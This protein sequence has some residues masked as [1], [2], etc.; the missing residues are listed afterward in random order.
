M[1]NK[2]YI[3]LISTNYILCIYTILGWHTLRSHHD[4]SPARLGGMRAI[5]HFSIVRSFVGVC[6]IGSSGEAASNRVRLK[7]AMWKWHLSQILH[8]KCSWRW[9]SVGGNFW[10]ITLHRQCRILPLSFFYLL[11]S[12]CLSVKVK[13]FLRKM[14]AYRCNPCSPLT[15]YTYR[16]FASKIWFDF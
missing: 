10:E 7:L 9:V 14:G 11:R 4:A 1:Y 6:C 15:I 5:P 16:Y 12:Y 8:R 3:Y 13:F 2:I